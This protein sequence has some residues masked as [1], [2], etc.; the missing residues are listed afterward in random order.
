MRNRRS[1]IR[2]LAEHFAR[3]YAP[4]DQTVKFTA[5][6][7]AKLQQHPWPGNVRELRNVLHRA[8]LVRKGPKLEASDITFAEPF[9]RAPVDTEGAAGATGGRHAGADDAAAGAPAH[10]EHLARCDNHK[11]RAAKALGLARSSLFKRLKEWG[12]GQE[13]G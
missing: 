12:L 4:R 1:D 8:L 3:L 11:D 13:E 5:A 10:R 7:L 9:H 2:P 6:A